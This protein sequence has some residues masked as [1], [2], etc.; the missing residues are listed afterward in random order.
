MDAQKWAL[1]PGTLEFNS[2]VDQEYI[3][4]Q[5]NLPYINLVENTKQPLIVNQFLK[6][7]PVSGYAVAAN[8]SVVQMWFDSTQVYLPAV[9]K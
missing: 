9:V 3:W 4:S 6:N 2:V 8:F 1:L 7:V 5:T